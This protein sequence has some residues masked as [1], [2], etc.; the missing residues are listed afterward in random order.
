MNN[1]GDI[2]YSQFDIA[3]LR[4]ALET[5]NALQYPLN[6]RN[7]LEAIE[8]RVGKGSYSTSEFIPAAQQTVLRLSG[9]SADTVIKE[10]AA[11]LEW[12]GIISTAVFL[13]CLPPVIIRHMPDETLFGFDS[14]IWI[15]VSAG[16][17]TL[18]ASFA[19]LYW[20]CPNCDNSLGVRPRRRACENCGVWLVDPHSVSDSRS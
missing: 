20:K 16:A 5:I 10:Y 15:A 11:L 6:Y 4:D 13:L 17:W 8:S 2:D 1:D 14:A 9:K 18:S 7:L 12:A 3:E 19:W